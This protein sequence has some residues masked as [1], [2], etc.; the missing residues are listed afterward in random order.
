LT[1]EEVLLTQKACGRDT[2]DGKES[3]RIHQENLR[4]S[5]VFQRRGAR[6]VLA[7]KKSKLHRMKKEEQMCSHPRYG[8]KGKTVNISQ[9]RR[10]G[11]SKTQTF[12]APQRS[13]VQTRSSEEEGYR[14]IK[15]ASPAG[16]QY[17]YGCLSIGNSA[18]RVFSRERK[19]K[20]SPARQ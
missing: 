8:I 18:A 9:T 4:A 19:V 1:L 3:M 10:R 13:F 6:I 2:W 15:Q 16:S 14:E 12:V 20:R 11:E 5:S 7:I 17:E